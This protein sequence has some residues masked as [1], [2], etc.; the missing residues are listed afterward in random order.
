MPRPAVR[1]GLPVGRIGQ[2]Q[3]H[4]PAVPGRRRP[5]YRRAHQRMAEHDPFADRQQPGILRGGGRRGTHA[6]RLGRAPDQQRI[7]NRF[8]CRNE[9]QHSRVVR[10]RVET[11]QIA[12]LDPPRQRVGGQQSET[13]RQLGRGQSARQL[14]EG[15]RI[16]PGLG[17]DPVAH[18]FVQTPGD[19]RREQRACVLVAQ[20]LDHELRQPAELLHVARLANREHH[21]DRLGLEATCDERQDLGGFAVEPLHVVDHAH[22]RP[23]LGRV[24]QQA[25]RSETEQEAIRSRSL[26]QPER[27][28]QR[29]LLRGREMV[30]PLEHPCAHELL[31]PG[32]RQLHLRLDATRPRDPASR[33]AVHEVVQ[34][35]GLPHTWLPA[36]DQHRAPARP[37]LLDHSVERNAFG[38]AASQPRRARGR[39]TAGGC[40]VWRADTVPKLGRRDQSSQP[41]A[42]RRRRAP[43][44]IP[45][46]GIRFRRPRS[47]SGDTKAN[48]LRGFRLRSRLHLG[49]PQTPA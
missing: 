14:E 48:P 7:A 9:Q 46:R 10:K 26:G 18:L 13:A 19:P 12:L 37:N 27:Q 39:A 40:V 32:Q 35:Y 43:R 38:A 44:T 1:V 28:P 25:E 49:Q 31:Q 22:E 5:V 2:R 11:A 20:P 3:V 17:N 8:R 16:A 33:S 30:D 47:C 21:R 23:L 15:E 29:L 24:G 6:E 41:R 45:N 36:N 4:R 34:Q 42:R